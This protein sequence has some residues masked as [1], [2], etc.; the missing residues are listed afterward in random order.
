MY[1]DLQQRTNNAIES[2]I[3]HLATQT[4]SAT[5]GIKNMITEVNEVVDKYE[6][7]SYR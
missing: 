3:G 2:E 1:E 4:S 7:L 5:E 6:A